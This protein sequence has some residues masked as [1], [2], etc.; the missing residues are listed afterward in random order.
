VL[1]PEPRGLQ[2]K[3]ALPAGETLNP[4]EWAASMWVWQHNKPAGA[5]TDTLPGS[6]RLY[7]PL[8][9]SRGAL[10]VLGVCITTPGSPISPDQRRLLQS[11]ADQGA[12]A[13]ERAQ[14]AQD[15]AETR[16]LAE[17]ERLRGALLSSISHDL[18]TPLT[19][20]MG[21]V[22]SLLGTDNGFNEEARRDLLVTIREEAERLNRFVGNLLDMTRLESGALH[23]NRDWVEIGDII[24]SA[25]AR[26][27][28]ALKSHRLVVHVEPGLPLL[29][30]DFVLMEQVLVNIL[31]NAAKYSDPATAVTLSALRMGDEVAVEIADQGIGVPPEDI[32]HIFDKFY[33]VRRG[34]RQVAGTGL[35]LS[36]CRGIVE[37]HGGRIAARTPQRGKGMVFTVTLP[38]QKSP[39]GFKEEE[40]RR[41]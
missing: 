38:V 2:V 19:S 21:A 10:G 29:S 6:D 17:T 34:D 24:G 28:N 7:V 41:D 16:S 15:M 3:A 8:S 5:G 31:D 13:I 23:L 35:G 11:L 33:R 30:L 20:I 14:L 4:N 40:A 36:I 27:E 12:V 18:R 26:M 22:T 25:L 39:A 1:L 37:A 32:E 9:T